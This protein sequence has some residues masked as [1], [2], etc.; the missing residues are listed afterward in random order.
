MTER[1]YYTD[2]YL[3]EFDANVVHLEQHDGH[4]AVLLDRTAF[5][6]ASGG[7][8]YDTGTLGDAAVIEVVDREDGEVL[9]VLDGPITAG[10]VHGRID[11]PRRFDHMQQHTGQHLLSAAF[12]RLFQVRTES[13]HLGAVSST[14]DLGRQVSAQEIAAAE[15][16]TN[17]IIWEDRPIAVR[18]ADAD[19]V[20]RLPLRKESARTGRLRLIDIEGFDMSACGGTHVGKTGTVGT[21]AVMSSER[22][23]G[24]SRVEFVAG[25]RMLRTFRAWRDTIAASVRIVSA[26]PEDLPAAIERLHAEGK[27]TRRQLKDAQTRLATFEAVE[28]AAR[29]TSSGEALIVIEALEGW[30]PSGLKQMASMIA[31]RERHIAVLFSIPAPS[32]VVIARCEGSAFDSSAALRH[33]LGRF[34]GKG[35]GRPDLAQGGGLQGTKAELVQAARTL[36]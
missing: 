29:A 4:P 2:P 34:G 25:V 17:R 8:P 16:E 12:D 6:P 19:E 30:D 11:W 26:L 20:A 15:D 33:L 35:G 36:F 5:Y 13:F 7:Q 9:H 14:V 32:A 31:K 21:V 23:R 22:F 27:E 1:L 24:G 10:P 18:F 3:T 28:L